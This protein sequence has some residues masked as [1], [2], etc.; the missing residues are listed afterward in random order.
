MV[1]PDDTTMEFYG[2]FLSD[3]FYTFCTSFDRRSE[4]PACSIKMPLDLKA[5]SMAPAATVRRLGVAS[6]MR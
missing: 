5:S 3:V 6:R 4:E 1:D 2:L